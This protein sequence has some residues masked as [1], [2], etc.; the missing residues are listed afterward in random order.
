[1]NN[2]QPTMKRMRD[3][4]T[5]REREAEVEVQ[6]EVDVAVEVEVEVEVEI[7]VELEPPTRLAFNPLPHPA[8]TST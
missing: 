5:E 7:K 3:W 4:K 1:M 6:R 2:E 8:A